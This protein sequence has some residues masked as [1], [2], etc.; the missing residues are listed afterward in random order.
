M[1]N[2]EDVLDKIN[3]RMPA[4]VKELLKVG[5]N[6]VTVIASAGG[7]IGLLFSWIKGNP[8]SGD[9]WKNY[10]VFVLTLVII[11]LFYR[12]IKQYVATK[13]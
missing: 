1:K 7:G 4:S 5:A 13:L 12:L 8:L 2:R 11:F 3:N 9:V 10:A 6:L